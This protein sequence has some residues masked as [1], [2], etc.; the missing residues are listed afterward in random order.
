MLIVPMIL[1]ILIL[2]ALTKEIKIKIKCEQELRGGME[3]EK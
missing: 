2:A 3:K 1:T